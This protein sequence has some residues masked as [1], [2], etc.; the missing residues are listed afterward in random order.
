MKIVGTM[1]GTGSI[2]G[3]LP[4]VGKLEGRISIELEQKTRVGSAIVGQSV[5]NGKKANN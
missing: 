4:K 5:V 1:A 2:I 3:S